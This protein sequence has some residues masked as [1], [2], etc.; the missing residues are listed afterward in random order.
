MNTTC[1]THEDVWLTAIIRGPLLLKCDSGWR[2]KS[3]PEN[4]GMAKRWLDEDISKAW[5]PVT[6]N[7]T[8]EHQVNA[9]ASDVAWYGLDF[10]LPS[11][12][13]QTDAWLVFYKVTGQATVWLNGMPVGAHTTDSHRLQYEEPHAWALNINKHCRMGCANRLIMRVEG[14]KNLEY[15]MKTKAGL[16]AP[17]EIHAELNDSEFRKLN[18]RSFSTA[19]T[20]FGR[21]C[22]PAG[23]MALL[24]VTDDLGP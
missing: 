13:S 8:L 20:R 21:F 6:L 18:G 2:Y 9:A 5:L 10:S 11:N 7:Q 23:S 3:D 19:T 24:S 22:Q 14:M 15:H 12:E 16:Y 17:V 4:Q 1:M